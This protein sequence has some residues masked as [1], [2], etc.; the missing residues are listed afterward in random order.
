LG[1]NVRALLRYHVQDAERK[2]NNALFMFVHLN[3]RENKAQK[4][5]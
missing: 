2:L 5:F 4:E 3:K 1:V